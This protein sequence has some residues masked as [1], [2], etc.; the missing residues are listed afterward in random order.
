MLQS[1]DDVA[2]RWDRHSCLSRMDI[3]V[4]AAAGQECPAAT[5]RNACP[6]QLITTPKS[7]SR[8]FQ[9]IECALPVRVAIAASGTLPR[10]AHE[11]ACQIA[12]RCGVF[13]S[14]VRRGDFVAQ[15]FG[16]P[17]CQRKSADHHEINRPENRM[18]GRDNQRK[19]IAP[20][21]PLR[22]L[23]AAGNDGEGFF[24]RIAVLRGVAFQRLSSQFFKSAISSSAMTPAL[25]G[26][27][28]DFAKLSWS[29]AIQVSAAGFDRSASS[30]RRTHDRKLIDQR[31]M[32]IRALRSHSP[33]RHPPKTSAPARGGANPTSCAAA[34]PETSAPAARDRAFAR[35]PMR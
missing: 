4:I 14:R 15:A 29:S 12:A 3:L 32:K 22:E 13:V 21:R 28:F 19:Q 8:I 26:S 10:S 17:G 6:T 34:G 33:G 35:G 9:L 2:F 7:D 24:F 16:Q 1:L 30:I 5:G 18:M 23:V 25:S 20:L 31:S 27:I 11:P